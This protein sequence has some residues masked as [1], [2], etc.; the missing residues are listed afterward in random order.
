MARGT[1]STRRLLAFGLLGGLAGGVANVVVLVAAGMA[2]VDFH[3][4]FAGSGSQW[5]TLG[6]GQVL[7]MSVV[8]AFPAAIGMVILN[9]LTDRSAIPFTALAALLTLASFAGPMVLGNAD[10][11]TKAALLLMHVV[12]AAAITGGMLLFAHRP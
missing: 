8:P 1:Y 6:A 7:L 11:G 2:G 12:A 10:L 9:R 3:G 5:T 4:S